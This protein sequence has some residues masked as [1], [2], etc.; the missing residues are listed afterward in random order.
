ME[1]SRSFGVRRT[2]FPAP[3]LFN[4]EVSTLDGRAHGR[5]WEGM[6][7]T[8]ADYSVLPLAVTSDL[9]LDSVRQRVRVWSYRKEEGPREMNAYYVKLSLERGLELLTKL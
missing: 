6:I 1:L 4:V 3:G 7:D 5:L 9:R 8:G 2:E